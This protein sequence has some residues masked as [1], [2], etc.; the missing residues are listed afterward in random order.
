MIQVHPIMAVV[1]RKRVIIGLDNSGLGDCQPV[2]RS[3]GFGLK[4]SKRRLEN[5]EQFRLPLFC[6]SGRLC[7]EIPSL[8]RVGP[9][10]RTVCSL[11]LLLVILFSAGIAQE[12]NLWN[13]QYGTRSTLLG[14]AV[15]GSVSDLSATYYNPGAIALFRNQS[16]LLSTRGYEYSSQS[17]EGG[18][19]EGRDLISSSIKPLPDL[20]A[21]SLPF[22]WLGEAS[23]SF[24]VLV[25]KRAETE[26]EAR[27]MV[28]PNSVGG[29]GAG[30]FIVTND[31]SEIW[32]GLTWGRPLGET[33]G[34]GV[35]TYLA[36]RDQ[37]RR[38]Q[39]LN[40][41][42]EAN[43]DIAAA[44][45]IAD[46]RYMH[47]RLLWKAGIG[48]DLSPL[49]LGVTVTT[50]GIGLFGSGSALV[51]A[52]STG[53]D[54]DGDGVDDN[55][56][57]GKYQPDLESDYRSPWSF[58]IGGSYA[59]GDTRIHVSGEYIGGVSMFDL[60]NSSDFV[61]QSSSDTIT[62][63]LTHETRDIF[64]YAVGLEYTFNEQTSGYMSFSTDIAANVR[65]STSNLSIVNYD[66]YHVAA[67]A[68]FTLNRWNLIVG[69][70]YAFGSDKVGNAVTTPEIGRDNGLEASLVGAKVT[71]Q[72]IRL[73]F[74]FSFSF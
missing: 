5:K 71:F 25:R 72:R 18:A 4:V 34:I 16:V 10:I 11:V 62:V 57:A 67:G 38:S 40:D 50:P 36:V 1:K 24:S 3:A 13:Q 56:L 44:I 66:I 63:S 2:P 45:Q 47:F 68:A 58:G 64:N 30:E 51:N 60:L 20:V 61:A 59:V 14:G 55:I 12:T 32:S 33:V 31:L 74:G 22:D 15:I 39:L 49:T 42:L 37:T 70:V 19:G 73:L 26:I 21:T 53:F 69:G 29:L 65:G 52:T 23:L 35:T 6:R 8:L 46:Y 54:Y 28:P 9:M 17:I 43:G 41:E 27:G 7:S 48:I